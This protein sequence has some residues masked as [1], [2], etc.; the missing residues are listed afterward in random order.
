MPPATMISLLPARIRSCAS[1]VAFM[2]EPHTLLIV[3]QPADSG[4]PAPSAAWRAG[5]WPTPAGSTQP[6]ITSST[7]SGLR[8]A[9]S[10]ADL[11]ATAPSCGV[12][13]L[14]RSPWKPPSGV[15]ATETMTTGS[16]MRFS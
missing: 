3:V 13:R 8:R 5:A 2:P 9:R 14:A 15:R 7:C 12:V 1:M 11:M 16:D 10:T 6:M 4:R